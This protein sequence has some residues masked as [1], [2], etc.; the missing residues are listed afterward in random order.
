MVSLPMFVLT[1]TRTTRGRR[2]GPFV[3]DVV[4]V[5]VTRAGQLPIT[6]EA[7]RLPASG[8]PDEVAVTDGYLERL[9]LSRV[10]ATRVLGQQVQVASGRVVD[11]GTDEHLQGRW[12]KMT[13]VGVVAQDAGDGQFLATTTMVDQARAWAER[14]PTVGAP[15]W[16]DPTR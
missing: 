3:D 11:S 14:G 5:D 12:A 1:S 8:S 7:G 13:I 9:G 2:V 6:V 4:G 16:G 15:C 10:Q